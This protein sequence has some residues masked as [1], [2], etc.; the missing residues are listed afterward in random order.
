MIAT[1]CPISTDFG[2]L[3]HLH[4][5]IAP[6]EARAMSIMVATS[7]ITKPTRTRGAVR[8]RAG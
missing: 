5:R 1:G 7:I 4:D 8:M 6:V 3:F 2:H